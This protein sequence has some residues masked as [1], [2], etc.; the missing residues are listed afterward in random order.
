MITKWIKKKLGIIDGESHAKEIRQMGEWMSE[1]FARGLHEAEEKQRKELDDDEREMVDKVVNQLQGKEH[2]TIEQLQKILDEGKVL[3]GEI[4]G[5]KP[6]IEIRNGYQRIIYTRES[7]R[8][9]R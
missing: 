1:G 3:P 2:E 4:H 7:N 9:E 8:N 5:Y 6:S